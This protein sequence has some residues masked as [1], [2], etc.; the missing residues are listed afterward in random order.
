MKLSIAFFC[1][2]Y[3]LFFCV[4]FWEGT[5]CS[6]VKVHPVC[7]DF[8][9]WAVTGLWLPCAELCGV[10]R[11]WGRVL[12]MRL[13]LAHVPGSYVWILLVD[14]HLLGLF[15]EQHR[16]LRVEPRKDFALWISEI[17]EAKDEFHSWSCTKGQLKSSSAWHRFHHLEQK[18]VERL[19]SNVSYKAGCLERTML[20]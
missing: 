2:A 15:P 5:R 7:C 12:E 16:L 6:S 9:F 11:V 1:T 10:C 19:F 8:P 14:L 20:R 18:E 17:Q 4:L 13:F 3:F